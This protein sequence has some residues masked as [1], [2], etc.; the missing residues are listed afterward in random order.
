M[1]ID[2]VANNVA[3]ICKILYASE[4]VKEVEFNS[5]DSN[6]KNGTYEKIDSIVENDVIN[7]H[8][9][10]LSNYY[11]ININT[12]IKVLLWCTGFLRNIKIQLDQELL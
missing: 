3:I 8:K 5:E 12:K 6:D 9:E 2:K 1:S 4:M 10:C 7:E 11:G